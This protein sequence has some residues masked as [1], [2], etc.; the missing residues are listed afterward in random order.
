MM[1]GMTTLLELPTESR[2]R[3]TAIRRDARGR[4]WNGDTA[5]SHPQVV[6]AFDAWITRAEDGRYCLANDINWAYF[7]LEGPPRFVSQVRVRADGG[8]EL[9]LSTGHREELDVASL[10]EG[11]DGVFYCDVEASAHHAERFGPFVAG[12]S[13]QAMM[14]LADVLDEDAEGAFLRLGE[15]CV[16]PPRVNDPLVPRG[17]SVVEPA[18]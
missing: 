8:V 12:F 16:R 5:I 2:S 13:S 14:G 3:E 18:P 6:R 11:P 7:A 17:R 1:R 9:T 15:H 4:W 10:R